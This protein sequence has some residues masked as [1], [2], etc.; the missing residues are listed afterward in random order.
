MHGEAVIEALRMQAAGMRVEAVRLDE[1]KARIA[2]AAARLYTESADR[3]ETGASVEGLPPLAR[4]TIAIVG[5]WFIGE[6]G[7]S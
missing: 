4:Q 3:L 6:E 5:E 7:G 2:R 1:R